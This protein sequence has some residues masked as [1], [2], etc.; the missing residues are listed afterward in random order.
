MTNTDSDTT[1]TSLSR[2][3]FLQAAAAITAAGAIVE[4]GLGDAPA[5][6][7]AA[8]TTAGTGLGPITLIEDNFNFPAH[9]GY[10]QPSGWDDRQAAGPLGYG[11]WLRVR[12]QSGQLPVVLT[13]RFGPQSD[14]D[15]VLDFRVVPLSSLDGAR[16]ELRNGASPIVVLSVASSTLR[17]EHAAGATPLAT[18]SP[19]VEVGLRVVAH[20]SDRITDVYVNG[21]AVVTGAP[22]L[23]S[24]TTLDN[25]MVSTGVSQT[26]DMQFGPVRLTRGF[27]LHESFI[28]AIPGALGEP[29]TAS[30]SGTVAL[31][32]LDAGAIADRVVMKLDTTALGSEC[33]VAAGFDAGPE[34]L[35]ADL[36][37]HS[38]SPLSGTKVKVRTGPLDLSLRVVRGRWQVRDDRN[39]W[40]NLRSAATNVWQQ[41]RVR[42][43]PT[44]TEARI[45]V[46]GKVCASGLRVRRM[47]QPANSAVIRFTTSNGGIVNVDDVRVF[48][49]P[50]DPSDYPATPVAVTTPGVL[51]GMQEFSGWREGHHS[52]W[53]TIKAYPTRLPLLGTY[54][55]GSPEVSDWEI[56]WMV[57]NGIS[58]RLFTWF[59]P[60]PG[61]GTPIKSP[62]LGHAIHDGFFEAKY[63]N[64]MKFAIMWET[65]A[66]GNTN[67]DDFRNNVVPF[68]IDYYFTDPRYLVIENKPVLSIYR[69]PLLAS[70]FGSVSAAADE[71]AYLRNAVKAAGFDDVLLLTTSADSSAAT[72]GLNAEY[73]YTRQS[74][75]FTAQKD[76]L[77]ALDA[78]SPVDVIASVGMGYDAAPWGARAGLETSPESFRSLA[79]WVR[80]TYLPNREP[81]EPSAKI[82]LLDNWNEF[83][84]GHYL[85]P[86]QYEGFAFVNAVRSVFSTEPF[87]ANVTPSQAQKER[88][89]RLYPPGRSIRIVER[90]PPPKSS[91]FA[92]DWDFEADQDGW[93]VDKQVDGL[94]ASES[95]LSGSAAGADPGLLSPDGLTIE[96]ADHPWIRV[97]MSA[98]PS[99]GGEIFFITEADGVWSESKGVSFHAEP[100]ETGFGVV[101]VPM[102]KVVTWK[103]R[104]RQIRLDPTIRFAPAV[105]GIDYVRIMRVPQSTPH[106]AV[107]G[108]RDRFESPSI[109][110]SIPLVPAE[111]VFRSLGWRTEFDAS[112]YA[113]N[114]VSASGTLIRVG[115]GNATGYQNGTPFTMEAPPAWIGQRV[116]VP[117]SLFAAAG[118]TT[119]WNQSPGLVEIS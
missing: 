16:W 98:S 63:S 97:R 73:I 116:Y 47:Q 25:L 108:I 66:G 89:S 109:V 70:I 34:R 30:G 62:F 106:L 117:Y 49:Q 43:D 90:T 2:R 113:V 21:V 17:L 72:I 94:A 102:W 105:F 112:S 68:W 56:K 95:I 38:A 1:S 87:P 26:S 119:A 100:D 23:G 60:T 91:D 31:S 3:T 41:I 65:Q 40:V 85:M 81:S 99:T 50:E 46:N 36:S 57:E 82:V 67:S 103:G 5:A 75:D 55:E 79:E 32:A 48:T 69:S 61:K 92:F 96:A 10:V 83:G 88:I 19:D 6:R 45:S 12:D 39:R 115:V 118:Y 11:Q 35:A 28:H 9:R 64:L 29:W 13:R 78:S 33:T 77:L 20:L 37:I 52:G 8:A 4:F 58:F 54:D 27:A 59:R 44:G 22:M 7:A 74:G 114:A 104:I 107:S 93:T 53:D 86:A 18:L 51:V 111:Y 71:I 24:G 84:E 101:D 42:L 14:C 15:L 76:T 110:G 80:D